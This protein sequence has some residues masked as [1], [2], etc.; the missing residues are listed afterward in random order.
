MFNGQLG[1]K[2]K[3]KVK[4]MVFQET[5][6]LSDIKSLYGTFPFDISISK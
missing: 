5:H 3:K 1:K 4:K 2:I 6:V